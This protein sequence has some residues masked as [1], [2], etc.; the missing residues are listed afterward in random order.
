MSKEII[1]KANVDVLNEKE[2]HPQPSTLNIPK[3]YKELNNPDDPNLF[4]LK[5]CIPFLESLSCGYILKNPIDQQINFNVLND[6][7]QRDTWVVSAGMNKTSEDFFYYNNLNI[8]KEYHNTAQLGEEKCPYVKQNKKFGFYKLLNPWTVVL[9]KGYSALY[10]QPLNRYEDRFEIFS[11][12]VDHGYNLPVNFPCVFKKQGTWVLKKGTP[13]ATV[14]PFKNDN[15]KMKTEAH[16]INDLKKIRF[17]FNTTLT[18]WYRNI[19]WKKK[20]WK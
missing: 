17:S 15:W 3:W 12:V 16:K 18:R 5:A 8:G 6:K 19:I 14:I 7:G 9:P 11:G 10:I 20:R 1:F 4:T 13:I 2:I